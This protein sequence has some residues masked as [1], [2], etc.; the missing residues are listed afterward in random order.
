MTF[1]VYRGCSD[2]K[3]GVLTIQSG[4]PSVLWGKP[5]PL[6]WFAAEVLG[7]DPSDEESVQDQFGIGWLSKKEH[8]EAERFI[9]FDDF[10][11]N[12]LVRS[13]LVSLPHWWSCLSWSVIL[14]AVHL[15]S[16][17]CD[18]RMDREIEKTKRKSSWSQDK[19]RYTTWP[20][21]LERHRIIHMKHSKKKNKE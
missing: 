18:T 19:N 13:H 7:L 16:W 2:G 11:A 20:Y 1:G 9:D 6:T 21:K 12:V 8:Q 4:S 5:T 3:R 17:G 10:T 15:V 14:L